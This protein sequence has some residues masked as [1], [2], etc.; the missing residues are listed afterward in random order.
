MIKRAL[1]AVAAFLVVCFS[2]P[3][4]ESQPSRQIQPAHFL[5]NQL[6]PGGA[7]A[8]H[9]AFGQAG[10]IGTLN[11]PYG[12]LSSLTLADGRPFAFPIAF[13]WMDAPPA[14]VLPAFTAAELPQVSPV[15]TTLPQDP[16]RK[17]VDLLPNFD[18]V[19]GEVGVFYGRSTGK[20][21]REVEQGYILGEVVDGNT[22]II[23]GGSYEHST[24]SVPRITGRQKGQ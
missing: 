12:G 14:D 1:P 22:H 16:D 5:M 13:A 11:N 19:G 18:Y 17:A 20:F 23:V 6:D 9:S 21:K 4:Q 3:A 8:R 15:T 2:L 7:V 24:G 10:I